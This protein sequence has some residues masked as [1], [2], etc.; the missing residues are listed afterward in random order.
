MTVA[1]QSVACI[2]HPTGRGR[3]DGRARLAAN[4]DPL[5]FCLVKGLQNRAAHR[6][7][8]RDATWSGRRRRLSLRA[9]PRAPPP[10]RAEPGWIASA[11]FLA[12]RIRHL[13][14]ESAPRRDLHLRCWFAPA[15]WLRLLEA[16]PAGVD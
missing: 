4:I 11:A 9:R 14:A 8:K 15:H 2:D 1:P 7:C 6:P 10:G 16:Q 12:P 13:A 3:L 5:V